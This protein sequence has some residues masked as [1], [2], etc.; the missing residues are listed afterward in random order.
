MS[1]GVQYIGVVSIVDL[2]TFILN[3]DDAEE[4]ITS[5]ISQA[6]G[7]TRES[8]SL[9]V[10]PVDRPLYFAMEQFCKGSLNWTLCDFYITHCL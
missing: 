1:N 7:S 9:W 4:R 10:E 2:L 5:R 3:G 8:M 6:I